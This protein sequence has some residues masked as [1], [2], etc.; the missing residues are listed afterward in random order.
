MYG[1]TTNSNN[2]SRLPRIKATAL[3]LKE[4]PLLNSALVG[5]EIVLHEDIHIGAAMALEEGLIVPVIRHADQKSVLEIHQTVQDLAERACKGDL[6]VDEVTGGTFTIT[7]LGMYGIDAFTPIINPPEVAIL[8]VG[9]IVE[10][11]ALINGQVAAHS[12]M[13]LS[14]T[15]G[16][17][18][19][20]GT[21]A[22][23]MAED[24]G[25]VGRSS[26]PRM[27][28]KSG[29]ILGLGERTAEVL[30]VFYD[31]R[32]AGCDLLALGQYLQPTGRQ[33]PVVRY[34]P[35]EEFTGYREKAE[36]IGFRRVV[37]GPLVRSS[38]QA[39]RLNG[40]P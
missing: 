9:R 36:T 40:L 10:E 19:G 34:V 31:R 26:T 2:A 11:L 8:G 35:P 24:F 17:K 22:L 37:A 27:V 5:E 7:N 6:S 12:R 1:P 23:V 15:G 29:L 4:Q 18:R 16:R 32:E 21:T 38:Y 25:R 13:V 30:R 20:A 3:A 33:Y 39:G 14:L 28:T